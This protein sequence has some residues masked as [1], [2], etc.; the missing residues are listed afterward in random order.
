MHRTT[1]KGNNSP[2]MGIKLVADL[3]NCVL[4]WPNNRLARQSFPDEDELRVRGR[5]RSNL[6]QCDVNPGQLHFQRTS[7]M[8]VWLKIK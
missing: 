5:V 7:Q 8:F 3:H 6:V 4:I 2:E 1:C